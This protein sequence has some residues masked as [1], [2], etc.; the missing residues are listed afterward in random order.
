MTPEMSTTPIRTTGTEIATR[1]DGRS[2]RKSHAA[3]G[4]T[5]TWVL[6]STVARPAPTC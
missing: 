6:P 3:S 1:A 4:T 5:T 2:P